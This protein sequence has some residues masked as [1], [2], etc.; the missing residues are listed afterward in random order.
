MHEAFALG[1]EEL[2]PNANAEKRNDGA[3]A[4]TNVWPERPEGFREAML[5]Y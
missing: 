4:G 1:W 3:M 2:E 5:Q